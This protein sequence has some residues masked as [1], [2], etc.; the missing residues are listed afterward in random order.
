MPNKSNNPDSSDESKINSPNCDNMSEFEELT[1]TS[2]EAVFSR[3]MVA[4]GTKKAS[5]VA[6]ALG[7]SQSSVS[8]SKRRGNIPDSWYPIIAQ[9]F[10]VSMDWLR[11]GV[12]E[13]KRSMKFIPVKLPNPDMVSS[14]IAGRPSIEDIR[15]RRATDRDQ[16]T[17]LGDVENFDMGEVLAQTIDILNSRTVYTT[18]IVSN[19]KAFHKAITTE[20]KI[21]DMQNRL[22]Q[23][24]SDFQDRLNRIHSEYEEIRAENQQLRE[25]VQ[26]LRSRHTLENTG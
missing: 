4:I 25:E 11:T 12:G 26:G 2:F 6:A 5:D 23:T 16:G 17:G 3:M 22:D 13:M 20:K 19:I 14:Q 21:D 9:K 15:D 8:G 7:I 10:G 18:A 24:L 1:A